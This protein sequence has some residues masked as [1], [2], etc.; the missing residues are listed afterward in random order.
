MT[1]GGIYIVVYHIHTGTLLVSIGTGTT[2][3]FF[4]DAFFVVGPVKMLSDFNNALSDTVPVTPLT[5]SSPITTPLITFPMANTHHHR[6]I[7][8]CQNDMR[9]FYDQ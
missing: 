1:L 3:E 5:L 4:E 2:I 7:L 8:G 6:A 9:K